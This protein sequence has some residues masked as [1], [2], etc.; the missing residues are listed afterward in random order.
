MMT[1]GPLHAGSSQRAETGTLLF[2]VSEPLLSF[3]LV[4]E[5]NRLNGR[6][7]TQSTRVWLKSG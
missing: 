2:V 6:P 4:G 5:D 1:S 3:R 7:W